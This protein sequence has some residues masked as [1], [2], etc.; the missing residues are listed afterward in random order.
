MIY[1]A[2]GPPI[3]QFVESRGMRPEVD[4][5]PRILIVLTDGIAHDSLSA[6][7]QNVRDQNIVIYAIGVA[8]YNLPL[9]DF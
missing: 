5:I 9:G 6:P 1:I 3:D 2:G 4:G 7:A 8:G